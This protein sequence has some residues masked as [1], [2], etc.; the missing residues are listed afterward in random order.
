MRYILFFTLIVLLICGCKK[1]DDPNSNGPD[2]NPGGPD[3]STSLNLNTTSYDYGEV[4]PSASPITQAFEISNNGEVEVVLD[5]VRV[6]GDY[7]SAFQFQGGEASLT[8]TISPDQTKEFEIT[9]TPPGSSL[10]ISVRVHLYIRSAEQLEITLTAR[11]GA[12]RAISL[13]RASYSYGEVSPGI[14]PVSQ[15]FEIINDS[16]TELILDSVRIRGDYANLFRLE[17]GE[18]SVTG[19]INPDER[20]Q[21]EISFTPPEQRGLDISVRVYFYV[22]SID[23][24]E[25]TL[26]ARTSSSGSIFLN[27]T[28]HDY[29]EVSPGISPI[30]QAFEIMNNN[31][32]GFII[33]SV[34]ISGDYADAF[35]LEGGEESVTGVLNSN[36]TKEFQVLFT[37][38]GQSSLDIRVSVRFYIRSSNELPSNVLRLTLT[39][40]TTAPDRISLDRTSHDY[41]EAYPGS[42]AI[43]QAFQIIN[44]NTIDFEIDSV[45]IRGDYA[46][47][48]QLEEG[49]ESVTGT[50]NPDET[51]DFQIL[52]TPPEEFDL[53]ISVRVYFYIRSVGR[54]ELSLVA[55]TEAVNNALSLDKTS[56]DYGEIPLGTSPTT[57]NFEVTNDA[58]IGLII[59]SVRMRGDYASAFQLEGGEASITG[60]IT[61]DQTKRFGISYTPPEGSFL[62]INVNVLIYIRSAGRAELRLRAQ[63]NSGALRLCRRTGK[64]RTG[65]NIYCTE[66]DRFD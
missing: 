8:G 17:G 52:F 55:R 53:N 33:D 37:P 15:A 2:N 41:G 51:K 46:N 4:S 60:I 21:F 30:S 11:T 34:R 20:R 16:T 36:E 61:P 56:H 27:T 54:L 40:R 58:E 43:T 25:L 28:S 3:G 1:S 65:G 42:S 57:Q 63:T 39:A 14:S 49:E 7:A 48:F 5:S 26:T 13:N 62:D 66:P 29:G 31:T 47:T 35:R 64:F 12:P 23:T 10:D 19:T 45:R 22:R 9:F 38:P 24:L 44:N 6:S 50:I 18:E 32:T 59:D